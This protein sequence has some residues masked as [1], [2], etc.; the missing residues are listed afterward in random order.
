MLEVD[1]FNLMILRLQALFTK[2]NSSLIKFKS[3]P[4]ISGA[5]Q[6]NKVDAFTTIHHQRFIL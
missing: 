4:N 2:D 1:I 6:Q 3:P 5:S